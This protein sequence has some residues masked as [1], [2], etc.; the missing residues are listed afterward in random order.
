MLFVCKVQTWIIIISQHYQYVSNEA[1]KILVVEDS[2][3]LA[4]MYKEILESKGYE[5][6]V[7]YD[8]RTELEI[9]EREL[10]NCPSGK[11][12]FDLIISDNLMPEINGVDAGK[13]IQGFVPDQK[14]FFVTGEKNSVLNSFDVDGKKIDVEQKP[15]SREIFLE[16]TIQLTQ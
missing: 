1:L 7:A 3:A 8:G 14:F 2:E 10:Q 5:I 15:V 16:K 9:Y 4:D 12:P 13:K 11:L 6:T